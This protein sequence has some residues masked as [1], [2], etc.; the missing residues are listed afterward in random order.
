MTRDSINPLIHSKIGFCTFLNNDTSHYFIV[1]RTIAQYHLDVNQVYPFHDSLRRENPFTRPNIDYLEH[2][3]E[4]DYDYII[5]LNKVEIGTKLFSK[6]AIRY[7]YSIYDNTFTEVMSTKLTS[8]FDIKEKMKWKALLNVLLKPCED[9]EE[10]LINVMELHFNQDHHGTK[11]ATPSS[12]WSSGEITPFEGAPVRGEIKYIDPYRLHFR[13][14]ADSP[15]KIIQA[16]KV[17]SFKTEFDT[18]R[19]I[20]VTH[21][22]QMGKHV[23]ACAINVGELSLYK[24]TDND[25]SKYYLYKANSEEPVRV[26]FTPDKKRL[27]NKKH[28]HALFESKPALA[29]KIYDPKFGCKDLEKLVYIYNR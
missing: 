1:K 13:L 11:Y 8:N 27:T 25:I 26:R 9:L 29:E 4:G 5:F 14:S 28:V 16:N 10:R 15:I 21:L 18:Y 19:T 23:F 20:F 7:W 2:K 24:L 3:I 22:G 12:D 6:N 17:Q